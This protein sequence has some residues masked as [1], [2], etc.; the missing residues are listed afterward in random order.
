M[1]FAR[2]RLHALPLASALFLTSLAALVA[3]PS[4]GCAPATGDNAE[5]T[6]QAS[7]A[8]DL[9]LAREMVG[10]LGGENGRC[11]DC[12]GV[13]AAK[14]RAWGTALKDIETAC[15]V[16]TL[17]PIERVNCLRS[18]PTNPSSPF[19]ARRLGLYAAGQ[20]A[21]KSVFDAAFPT[22][23]ASEYA[24]FKQRAL[25]PRGDVAPL[26][27]DEF[28]K[29][30][31]WVLRGMPQLDQA[32]G[33]PP[34]DA[35]AD[36]S[37]AV[38]NPRTTPELA[39][40]LGAMKTGGWGA[41]LADQATPMFGCNGA[42]SALDCLGQMPDV[43]STFAAP[44]VPQKVRRLHEQPLKSRYWVR[45]SAD[46]RYVG[47]GLYTSSKIVDLQRPGTEITVAANYDPYFLPGND[48][49]AFAGSHSGDNIRL[50]RQSLL[51]GLSDAPNPSVS[52]TESKCSVVGRDVYQ[53]I[54][55][56]LDGARYFVTWGAHE[57]DD[58]GNQITAPLAAAFSANASTTFT[59]MVNNG[60]SYRAESPVVVPLPREGDMMLS[61]SGLVAATR[62][63]DGR[64]QRGYRLRFVKPQGTGSSLSIQLPLAAE[65]CI[66]GQK[67]GFSFDERFVVTHQ[68][69]D[70]SE[71]DQASLP[72]KS[73]NIMI[74]DLVTGAQA[75][76][77]SS[78]AGQYALYPH[79]R[80]D[81]WLYFIV[82]D[83]NTR[84]EFAVASDVA[85]RMAQQ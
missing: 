61:P 77:T 85:L 17:T 81:G 80:A 84:T 39:A 79:F 56:A 1:R 13:T 30:K 14:V 31:G 71:P 7:T 10:L 26:N 44:N 48:G 66:P 42:A 58:G 67:M 34:V 46:G 70:R 55:A 47:W 20:D 21:L 3:A 19:A 29:L 43:T 74:V 68:Y 51:A 75:R 50:C 23:A 41:R 73:A 2:M 49:F 65:L 78:K 35:G 54:G 60:L 63:G 5:S 57:N 27:A 28:T 53:S 12:H 76:V 36:A 72:A 33:A 6:E 18:S 9:T 82:R 64:K 8:E 45:S 83:M 11:N 15:F 24:S 25:M 32:F 37:T 38:C 40:H 22:T 16:P 62:F 59:P 69:V 4:S 52:L